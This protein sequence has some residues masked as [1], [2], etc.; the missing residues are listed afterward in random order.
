MMLLT[1]SIK[2]NVR[3]T[4]DISF[5]SKISPRISMDLK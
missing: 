5:A 3:K 2:K 4:T 1:V